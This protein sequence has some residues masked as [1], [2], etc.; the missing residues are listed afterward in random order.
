MSWINEWQVKIR[1]SR[2]VRSTVRISRSIHPPGFEGLSLH[3]VA[4][5]FI[6]GLQKGALTTRAAAISFR[7]FMAFFPIIII[8]LSLIPKIP[9][10]GFQE[11]LFTSIEGFFPGDTYQL[12]ESTLNDL[13]NKT[14]TTFLSIGFILGFFYASSSINAIW[15]G[16]N[17]SYH[18]DDRG[19]PFLMRLVSVGVLMI[20]GL[21]LFIAVSLVLFSGYAFDYLHAIRIIPDNGILIILEVAKW[22][23]VVMLIYFSITILYNMGNLKRSHWKMFSAGATFTTILFL[24]AS[25][26]FAWFVNNFAQ[27]NRLYGSLGTLILLLIWV[28]FNSIILLL[29]FELNTSIKRAKSVVTDTTEKPELS[30]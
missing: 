29:G 13:V 24:I 10:E 19:N 23:I 17:G 22:L 18:L 20:L 6:E 3:Y 15:L 9:V 11:E 28:N 26:L 5:Y 30:V 7:L 21:L 27:F 2:F 25:I 14:H 4:R 16:F 1:R 8:L 12:V